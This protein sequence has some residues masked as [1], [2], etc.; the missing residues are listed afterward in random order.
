MA[1]TYSAEG[2]GV[3]YAGTFVYPDPFDG[4]TKPYANADIHQ[5]S[6]S[7]ANSYATRTRLLSQ[8]GVN[9]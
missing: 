7:D 3:D 8:A 9:S 5:N 2:N 4:D 1:A 6:C